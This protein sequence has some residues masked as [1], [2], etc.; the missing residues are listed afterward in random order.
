MLRLYKHL[1]NVKEATSASNNRIYKHMRP[2][3][4]LNFDRND[5]LRE[6]CTTSDKS[7]A[8][9]VNIVASDR[10]YPSEQCCWRCKQPEQSR[11]ARDNSRH[12]LCSYCGK[13]R[14]FSMKCSCKNP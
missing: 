12:L 14:V 13:D 4:R 7:T 10:P 3:Y 1:C 11:R 2:E 5:A 6:E 8:A 9:Y